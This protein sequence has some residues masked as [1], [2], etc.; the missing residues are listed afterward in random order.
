[1]QNHSDTLSNVDRINYPSLDKNVLVLGCGDT[2]NCRKH[3][4]T[5]DTIDVCASNNPTLVHDLTTPLPEDV[6][7]NKKFDIIILEYLPRDIRPSVIKHTCDLLNPE[8]GII[9]MLGHFTH[10]SYED[11]EYYVSDDGR[12]PYY[13]GTSQLYLEHDEAWIV[14]RFYDGAEDKCPLK[15]LI[16]ERSVFDE[17]VSLI[18]GKINKKFTLFTENEQDTM[19]TSFR[20]RDLLSA[21]LLEKYG[22]QGIPGFSTLNSMNSGQCYFLPKARALVFSSINEDIQN[23]LNDN[24]ITHY[25]YSVLY[26]SYMK[27]R[28]FSVRILSPEQLLAEKLETYCGVSRPSVSLCGADDD[29]KFLILEA[30]LDFSQTYIQEK[31]N[32]P[33]TKRYTRQADKYDVFFVIGWL[34]INISNIDSTWKYFFQLTHITSM[35]MG[36]TFLL[37]FLTQSKCF[38]RDSMCHKRFKKNVSNM[39]SFTFCLSFLTDTMYWALVHPSLHFSSGLGLMNAVII[40]GLITVLFLIWVWGKGQMPF[41]ENYYRFKTDSCCNKTITGLIMFSPIFIMAGAYAGW[42]YWGQRSIYHQPIYDHVLDWS[43]PEK[44]LT[45]FG[46]IAGAFLLITLAYW[47]TAYYFRDQTHG[48]EDEVNDQNSPHPIFG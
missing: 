35:L 41:Q 8:G 14:T 6:F 31:K 39:V 17:I 11:F 44:T 1:M 20:L 25:L 26:R 27:K 10:N 2:V 45:T 34:L 48:V 47:G 12:E 3:H 15:E 24:H 13:C 42:T 46:I 43:N 9:L 33:R 18:K 7:E 28:S 40:H 5:A 29:K 21:K 4:P 22:L 23:I 36:A 32:I 30:P 16:T 37:Y 19:I 38:E